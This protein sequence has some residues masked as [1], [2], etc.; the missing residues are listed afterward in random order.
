MCPL[1]RVLALHSN[2]QGARFVEVAFPFGIALVQSDKE[3]IIH[4]ESCQAFRHGLEKIE[5]VLSET[6]MFDLSGSSIER[7]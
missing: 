2:C 5:Y 4:L 7:V 3:C 1:V 6:R